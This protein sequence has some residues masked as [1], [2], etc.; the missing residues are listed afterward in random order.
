MGSSLEASSHQCG[1]T[2]D[3]PL[4]C[5]PITRIYLQ[6]VGRYKL[7]FVE[8]ICSAEATECGCRDEEGLC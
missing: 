3:R 4:L 1:S 2:R 7:A 5:T 8:E 6:P